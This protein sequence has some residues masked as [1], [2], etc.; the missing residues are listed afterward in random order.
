MR[1]HLKR[2]THV[3]VT[4]LS[5]S[6]LQRPTLLMKQRS[7]RV[8][9]RVPVDEWQTG[10][11]TSWTQV[12]LRK[13]YDGSGVPFH[14]RAKLFAIGFEHGFLVDCVRVNDFRH[15][16]SFKPPAGLQRALLQRFIELRRGIRGRG[17]THRC[18]LRSAKLFQATTRC[19]YSQPIP[20]TLRGI[21]LSGVNSTRPQDGNA[22][23]G[24]ANCGHRGGSSR[25]ASAQPTDFGAGRRCGTR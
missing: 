13:L 17:L 11:R 10:A 21:R 9:E 12:R 14:V 18:A 15:R 20:Y 4:E 6:H 23:C 1:V 5:L 16:W 3:R 7:V 2:G 8:P 22:S 24:W 19:N 25:G